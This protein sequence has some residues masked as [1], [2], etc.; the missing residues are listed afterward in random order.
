MHCDV[1]L[2]SEESSHGFNCCHH[3]RRHFCNCLYRLL[4]RFEGERVVFVK[5]SLETTSSEPIIFRLTTNFVLI[6]ESMF[7]IFASSAYA[8]QF[9]DQRTKISV[10][11]I[12]I[13]QHD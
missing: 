5:R 13:A 9:S 10:L 1:E 3:Y 7:T 4:S 11:N 12:K 6:G 8:I 2:A